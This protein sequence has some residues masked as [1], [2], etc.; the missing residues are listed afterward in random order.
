MFEKGVA[1]GQWDYLLTF[2]EPESW[3]HGSLASKRPENQVS[4]NFRDSVAKEQT[5]RGHGFKPTH[6]LLEP[7][8]CT[9]PRALSSQ[10]DCIS[11]ALR[12]PWRDAFCPNIQPRAHARLTGLTTARSIR[13]RIFRR[14][15]HDRPVNLFP[16]RMT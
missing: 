7:D 9:S 11:L 5:L 4:Q 2:F 3:H 1:R 14:R 15:A 6:L 13:S 8:F 12:A 10:Q 16:A